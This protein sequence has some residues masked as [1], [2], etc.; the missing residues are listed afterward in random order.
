LFISDGDD[1]NNDDKEVD[2]VEYGRAVQESKKKSSGR[3]GRKAQWSN[4]QLND[5]IDIIVNNE[6][7]RRKLI[8]TNTKNQKNAEVY[9]KVLMELQSRSTDRSEECPFGVEQLRTK[10]KKCVAECKKAAMDMKTASGVVRFQEERGYGIWFSSLFALVKTRDSCQPDQ[11]IEPSANVL[12]VDSPSSSSGS[13]DWFVPIPLKRRKT[14]KEKQ[15]GELIGLMKDLAEKNP[16]KEFLEYAREEA[17][18]CRQ[19]ELRLMQPWANT[20]QVYHS[21]PAQP[22]YQVLGQQSTNHNSFTNNNGSYTHSN[23][24]NDDVYRAYYE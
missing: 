10:F 2:D 22:N 15:F 12:T 1:N 6:Y 8:F 20:Q 21:A 11:A 18:K 9:A 23:N 24:N 13:Q 16:M 3:P 7:F 5:L 17:D 4:T 14:S 19:H